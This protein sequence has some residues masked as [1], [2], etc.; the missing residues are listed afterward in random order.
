MRSITFTAKNDIDLLHCGAEFFPRLVEAFDAA[1]TEI[2]LETYI[3]AA[4]PT[5]EQIRLALQR[6]AG[7]GV[8]V[9]VITDWVGTGRV[10]SNFL[11][12][13][14]SKAGVRHRSFNPWFRNGVARTHRKMC[15]VDRK[16]AFLGGLNINDDLISDDNAAL[17]LP[18]PRWDFGVRITGPLV[19]AI[20]RE[21]ESQWA[22]LGN[23]ALHS[24]WE[25]FREGRKSRFQTGSAPALAALVVRDNLRNRRTIQRT[26]LHAL[27]HARKSALIANPY[28]APGRKL[29]DALAS[30]AARGVDVTLLLGVGQFQLQDAVAHSFY[31]KLLKSGVKVVEY[32]KTQLH[33]KV[34]VIDDEWATVGSSNY[35]GFS[36][37]VNQEANIVIKDAG[38]TQALREHIERGIAD[39]VL[40]RHDEFAHNP[41]YRRAYY[42]A[43][44]FI[45]RS[46]LRVITLGKYTE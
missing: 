21:I 2:C 3:F 26:F 14:F 42:G 1:T 37:F 7:R 30:A 28:F 36:L 9:K 19:S 25:R 41:W 16:L 31:P 34:A 24:R 8:N 22:R 4:D 6:A 29:R 45:Y 17:P 46:I 10:Q 39:G 18:A 32:R 38:F 5:A 27:G 43:A 23:L 40:I 20:H 12:N 44:Y 33:G 35:D 13:E 15:V 11:D